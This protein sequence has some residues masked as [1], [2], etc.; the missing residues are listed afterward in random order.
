MLGPLR[1]VMK[2]NPGMGLFFAAFSMEQDTENSGG[3][4]AGSGIMRRGIRREKRN[5]RL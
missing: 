1:W 4:A 2:I 3:R 5:G